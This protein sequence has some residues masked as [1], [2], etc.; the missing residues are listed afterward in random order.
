MMKKRKIEEYVICPRCE[1]E[2][3]KEVIT[4]PFCDFGILAWLDGEIDEDGE[5]VKKNDDR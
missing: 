5:R 2:V 4:C 1:Q 3:S